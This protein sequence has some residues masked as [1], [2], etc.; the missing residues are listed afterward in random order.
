MSLNLFVK[1]FIKAN[2]CKIIKMGIRMIEV[3]EFSVITL[4][5]FLLNER[6]KKK[7][8]QKKRKID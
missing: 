3:S 8:Q 2:R 6:I 7:H 1:L 5:K 4:L